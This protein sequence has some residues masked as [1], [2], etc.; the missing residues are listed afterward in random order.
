MI[1]TGEIH[2]TE[3]TFLEF[4]SGNEEKIREVSGHIYG[5]A[6]KFLKWKFLKIKSLNIFKFL[7]IN[8]SKDFKI[9]G[10]IKSC[11]HDKI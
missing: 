4:Y 3:I 2:N 1:R 5:K 9:N 10:L 8:I 7:H 6:K 11:K